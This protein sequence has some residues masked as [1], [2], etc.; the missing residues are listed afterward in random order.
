[1]RYAVPRHTA[2]VLNTRLLSSIQTRRNI[3]HLQI[4]AR[5]SPLP[6]AKMPPVGLGATEITVVIKSATI[7][8]FLVGTSKC[9]VIL[10][11]KFGVVFVSREIHLPEFLWPCSIS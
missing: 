1:M 6:V 2:P 8:L 4:L 7:A 9:G 11:R 10:V 5:M 3:T